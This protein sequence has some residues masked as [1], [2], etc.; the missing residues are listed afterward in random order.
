M[1]RAFRLRRY[2]GNS[3]VAIYIFQIELPEI[4]KQIESPSFEPN[5]YSSN[6]ISKCA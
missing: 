4:S 1:I 2:A 6:R 5:L 3:F